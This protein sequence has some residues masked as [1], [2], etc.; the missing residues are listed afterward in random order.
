MFFFVDSFLSENSKMKT[1][2]KKKNE[3]NNVV[4]DCIFLSE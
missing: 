4:Q 2:Q 3:N 1:K